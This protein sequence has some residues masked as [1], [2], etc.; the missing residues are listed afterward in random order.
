[1]VELTVNHCQ[2]EGD[3]TI[4]RVAL[5]REIHGLCFYVWFV[6]QIIDS[7]R[8]TFVFFEYNP[9]C[10]YFQW[11]RK[12]SCSK[13]NPSDQFDHVSVKKWIQK[14]LKLAIRLFNG[15][16]IQNNWG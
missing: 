15:I 14:G 5:S 8:C 2:Y 3:T 7:N 11:T 1:M 6:G 10:M 4:I 13:I 9:K 16:I 12:I